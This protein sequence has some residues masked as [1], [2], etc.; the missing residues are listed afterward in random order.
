MCISKHVAL[1]GSKVEIPSAMVPLWAALAVDFEARVFD[2]GY[3]CQSVDG[4]VECITGVCKAELGVDVDPDVV[5]SLFSHIC[6]HVLEP[7]KAAVY[8]FLLCGRMVDL[9]GSS[10]VTYLRSKLVRSLLHVAGEPEAID[11]E[12]LLQ[13]FTSQ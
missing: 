10:S 13:D 11:K 9:V 4:C 5:M 7:S 8:S 6:P 3:G 12:T 2:D 1:Q